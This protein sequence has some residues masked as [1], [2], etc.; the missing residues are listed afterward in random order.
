M[1]FGAAFFCGAAYE[2]I[3]KLGKCVGSGKPRHFLLACKP[4]AW[5][6]FFQRA[7]GALPYYYALYELVQGW[8]S[9]QAL[10][11]AVLAK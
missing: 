8:A 9:G 10:A 2:T 1:G 3:V 7:R 11:L 5:H 4:L 6:K